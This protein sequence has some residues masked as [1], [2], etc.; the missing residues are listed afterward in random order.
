MLRRRVEGAL[1]QL[2]LAPGSRVQLDVFDGVVVLTGIVEDPAERSEV[3]AAILG[4][5]DVQAVVQQLESRFPSQLQPIPAEI[6]REALVQLRQ[7]P[8]VTDAG[9]K[10]VAEHSWLRVEGVANSRGTHDE[11]VRR[12]RGVKGSRGVIDKLRILGPATAQV[13]ADCR[14]G[15]IGAYGNR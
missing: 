11:V 6:A 2:S 9:I 1:E 7:S 8:P 4:V 10:I 14:D 5:P 3:E 13:V 12:L 15:R